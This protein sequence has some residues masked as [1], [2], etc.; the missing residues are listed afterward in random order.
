[1]ESRIKDDLPTTRPRHR[2]THLA[3]VPPPPQRIDWGL[4]AVWS[5]IA[6]PYVIGAIVVAVLLLR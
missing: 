4:V 5:A 6:A 2:R 1:M 3:L